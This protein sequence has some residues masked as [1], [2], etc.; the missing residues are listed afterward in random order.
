MSYQSYSAASPQPYNPKKEYLAKALECIFK[1]VEEE[2]DQFCSTILSQL[3]N[4]QN[5]QRQRLIDNELARFKAKIKDDIIKP[6]MH[7][8]YFLYDKGDID[9]N[10][11]H[12]HAMTEDELAAYSVSKHYPLKSDNPHDIYKCIDYNLNNIMQTEEMKLYAAC[13]IDEYYDQ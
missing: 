7:E 8:K 6:F 13:G 4:M 11:V 10:I 5:W 3:Q 2:A 1:R 9:S 12:Y